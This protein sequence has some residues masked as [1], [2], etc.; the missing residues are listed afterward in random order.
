MYMTCVVHCVHAG[1]AEKL[2][3]MCEE[4]ADNQRKKSQVWPLQNTLLILCPVSEGEG[5]GGGRGEERG[6][7][8][9]NHY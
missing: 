7:S 6:M 1:S 3:S 4:F 5:E 2:F 9:L 8:G